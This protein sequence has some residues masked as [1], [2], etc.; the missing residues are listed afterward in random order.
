MSAP[1]MVCTVGGSPQ[2]VISAIR[3]SRPDFVLFI[4]TDQEGSQPGSLG[5][6]AGERGIAARTGLGADAYACCVVPSDDP[7]RAF[8]LIAEAI[9]RH[10]AHHAAPAL[11]ADYTGGTKSMSA[12]LLAAA[13]EVP[14]ATLQVMA[15]QRRDLVKV[16]DGTERPYEIRPDWMLAAREVA[17]LRE[18]WRR[19]GYAETAEGLERLIADLG[20]DAAAAGSALA[21]WRDLAA[22][23]AG[24]AAWD[25]F[26]HKTARTLLAPLADRHAA[27]LR[28]WLERLD[29]LCTDGSEPLRIL[30][31]WCNAER[32]A[33]RGRFDDAVAR[34]YRLIEWVGQWALHARHGIDTSDIKHA[35]P[36]PEYARRAGIELRDGQKNLGGLMPTLKLLAEYE[37]QGRVRRFL[38]DPV[39]YKPDG[40]NGGRELRNMLELRNK[41]ILAHGTRPLA[42]EDWQR[43]RTFM[44]DFA[45]RVVVPELGSQWPRQLPDAPPA[46]L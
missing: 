32:R 18:G 39:P 36:D 37:P 43:F 38:D 12:A 45:A 6:I 23:S 9:R 19:Y 27:F 8:A 30:D 7:D 15:G 17:R 4:V 1:I 21:R 14:R 20:T 22:L 25:R 2:P 5:Q 26:E 35:P 10:A 42:A 16:A 24:F 34:F 41:S 31:L 46:E 3:M 29:A 13:L 33:E 28:S 40:R 11:I 44:Q